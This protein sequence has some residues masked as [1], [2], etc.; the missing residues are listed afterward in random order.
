MK[1]LIFT[2]CIALPGLLC[3][4]AFKGGEKD[5]KTQPPVPSQSSELVDCL[6]KYK[7]SQWGSPCNQC[8]NSKDTFTVFYKNSC[9][10]K[11]DVVIGVMEEESKLWRLS[12]F[13]GVNA[14]DT[15]KAYACKGT[16]KSAKWVREAGDNSYAIPATSDEFDALIGK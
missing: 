7:P 8:G 15:I 13:M 3:L 12:K 10:K 6:I 1:K 9:S 4:M 2:L 5:K 16:G 11:L 14:N